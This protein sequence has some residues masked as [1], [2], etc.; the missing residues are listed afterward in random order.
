MDNQFKNVKT[1]ARLHSKAM[2]YEWR[3]KLLEGLREGLAKINDG[4][5]MD[6]RVL[7]QQEDLLAPVIPLLVEQHDTLFNERAELQLHAKQLAECDQEELDDAREKLVS[8]E[9]DLE[10]KRQLFEDMKQQLA[11]KE[12]GIEAAEQRKQLCLEDIKESNRIR[13]ECRGWSN[14]EVAALHGM[15]SPI[16]AASA[17]CLQPRFWPWKRLTAGLSRPSTTKR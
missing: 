7:R 15:F 8:A 17:Y 9:S 3:M 14:S 6:D 12:S 2:W 13:E 4:M 1:H 5:M 10:A 11:E 16:L